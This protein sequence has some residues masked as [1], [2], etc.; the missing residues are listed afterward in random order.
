[1]RKL[2]SKEYIK[3]MNRLEP[4]PTEMHSEN[5]QNKE[6]ISTQ[7]RTISESKK[8]CWMKSQYWMKSIITTPGQKF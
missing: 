3:F 1:M 6:V 2:S 7:A 8:S 4:I 5:T